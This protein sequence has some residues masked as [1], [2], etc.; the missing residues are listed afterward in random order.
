MKRK[1]AVDIVRDNV[2]EPLT[3]H[4]EFIRSS[5]VG[6]QHHQHGGF[7]QRPVSTFWR[8]EAVG[9]RCQPAGLVDHSPELVVPDHRLGQIRVEKA[10]GTVEV[11]HEQPDD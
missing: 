10:I 6:A 4:S 9:R 3:D 11:A 1:A 7:A 8:D 5:S 2:D